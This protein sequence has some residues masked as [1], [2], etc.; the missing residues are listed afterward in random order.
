MS[1]VSA[2][3]IGREFAKLKELSS[4]I[5]E[6]RLTPLFQPIIR[7]DSG[8]IFGYEGLI[9]A[10]ADSP[11]HYPSAL[12]QAAECH[13]RLRELEWLCVAK[14][15]NRFCE[16]SLP[17]HLF[18][19]IGPQTVAMAQAD[20]EQMLSAVRRMGNGRNRIVI[21]LTEHQPLRATRHFHDAMA[22]LRAKG[23]G[24]ALDDLGEGFS[25]LKLWSD[26]RPEY[27]KI[28][29]HFVQGVFA[30]PFKF[31]FLKSLQQIAENCGAAL[32]AEGIENES[33][34]RVVRNLGV[35]YGQ[36][37]LIARPAEMPPLATPDNIRRHLDRRE[38][39]V[40]PNMKSLARSGTTVA[41]LTHPVSAVAPEIS[42][43][44]IFALFEAG[45]DIWALPV[46]KDGAPLGIISRDQFIA[47]YARPYW[48]ELYGKRPCTLCMLAAP[49][50]VERT[51][52]VHMLSELLAEADQR[53]LAEGFMVV[54]GG[55][56][57]GLGTAQDLIREITRMQIE[58]AR[59]ANPL[60]MLPGNVPINEH[61]ERLLAA[62]VD[63]VACY[64]DLNEFKPFNDKY[65]YRRGDEMIKIAA[66]ILGGACEPG[67]D[68]LGHIGG[69]DFMV[70]FQSA[71]WEQRC[72]RALEAFERDCQPL[73]DEADRVR[74]L[75][76]GEDRRGNAVVFNLTSLSLG[77]VQ[78]KAGDYLNHLDVAA[79]A[80][81]AK[82]QAKRSGG[83]ALFVERRRRVMQDMLQES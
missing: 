16:L 83:N 7:L 38:I 48:R 54:E 66:G 55:R 30:D 41:R 21:E 35:A 75:F 42:N 8:D 76:E 19:N 53:V 81:E 20:G 22:V 58:A 6:G 34:L 59:Y 65:G 23:F 28:D 74:G 57:V 14:V 50:I 63:F 44:R 82:K 4:I 25:G 37:Y 49:V 67:R 71:D 24:V 43:D 73:F 33:D 80:A 15:V 45:P 12:F 18:V 72:Q 1:I 13:G 9:R 39:A 56:Y 31:Q 17:N 36:G 29:M 51:A 40:Y 32:I 27:I 62:G 70:L 5:D 3:P 61:V 47:Q 10:P 69:D 2:R 68:F 46:V 11:L 26:L 77:A 60:T 64:A 79:A 52:T 78:V